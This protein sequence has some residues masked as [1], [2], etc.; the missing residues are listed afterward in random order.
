MLAG[1]QGW[2]EDLG[3]RL[4]GLG[5]RV[6]PV[7]FVDPEALRALYAG[8][9]VFCFPSLEEGF[10]LPVLEAMAQGTAVVTSAGTATAEVVG[11]AGVLVDPPDVDGLTDALARL[12]DDDGERRRLGAAGL[13]GRPSG[14][15]GSTPPRPSRPCSPR[16]RH[17]PRCAPTS[18]CG[19]G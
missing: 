9:D 4:A 15:P 14:S 3:E 5:D 6:R 1:P 8:A 10:G 12:L 7:G 11:D 2:N 17:G 19:S 18:A 16:R 13:A